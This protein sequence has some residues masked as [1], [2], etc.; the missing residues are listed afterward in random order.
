MAANK[1]FGEIKAIQF[2]L[3][4]NCDN[5]CTFCYS[6]LDR[7]NCTPEQQINNINFA[8]NMISDEDK[9]KDYNCVALIGGEFF[10]GQL[11]NPEVKIA[12]MNLI[13]QIN[14]LMEEGKI[15][16]VWLAAT[17][18][19][20]NQSDLYET[21]SHFTDMTKVL[22]NTSYDT[23]GRYHLENGKEIWLNNLRI[24][25]EKYDGITI[26][27]QTIVTQAFIDETMNPET[28][29]I[30][31]IL[32]YSLL[33]FKLPSLYMEDACTVSEAEDRVTKHRE[34]LMNT[35]HMYPEKF[36]IERRCDFIKFCYKIKRIFGKQKLKAL[37]VAEVRSKSL[38]LISRDFVNGDRWDLEHN[39]EMAPCGHMIDSYSYLDSDKCARCDVYSIYQVED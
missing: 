23:L 25:K 29:M 12:F 38:Y 13:K 5:N 1:T 18:T 30:M 36:F 8:S 33:D 19:R 28:N 2:E 27:T 14:K 35:L 15:E 22:I 16:E 34:M 20:E 24:L 39:D 17:L 9:M 32:K 3:W 7:I 6:K 26:H 21:L 4:E 31:K 37:Y 10:Q 11:A